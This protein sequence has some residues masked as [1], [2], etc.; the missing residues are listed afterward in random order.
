MTSSGAY[1]DWQATPGQSEI[2]IATGRGG[3]RWGGGG[4]GRSGIEPSEVVVEADDVQRG[5]CRLA[6]DP[7]PVGDRHRH[8]T[9]RVELV[10]ELGGPGDVARL[11]IVGRSRQLVADAPQQHRRMV[12]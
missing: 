9:G 1:A 7:G 2:A 6:G 8:R 3:A 4:G 10:G 5:I 12:L 11:G